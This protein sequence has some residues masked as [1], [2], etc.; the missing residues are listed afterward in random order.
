MALLK[1]I[2]WSQFRER[3]F[4]EAPKKDP[5]SRGLEGNMVEPREQKHNEKRLFQL[6]IRQAFEVLFGAQDLIPK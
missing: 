5:Y 6:Q 3:G 1:W 4:E 2:G